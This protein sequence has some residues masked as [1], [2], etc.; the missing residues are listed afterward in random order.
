MAIV[1]PPRSY[2]RT[3]PLI[4]AVALFMENMD[5][6]VIATSLPAI[7]RA[8]GTNPLA[9]K[10]AVT[11]YLLALAIFIPASGWTADRFGAR[12][13]FRL[14]IFVFMLGSIGCA[15]SHSLEEF[16]LARIIQG[17]GG[18][19][20]TPV[21][22]LILVRSIDKRLLVNAMSLVTIPALVGPICGPPLGGFITTYASW[23]WIF[24][25]NIPIGLAG[26]AMATR[27]MPMVVA[28]PT[29][30]FDF[31]GFVL[32]GLG[33]GG[34]AFGLSVMGLEFL[35]AGIVIGLLGVGVTAT[36]A[37]IVHAR[38][39]ASP[40]LDLRLF[41]LP[42]F[43][44][45]IFGGFMFRLGIGALPF[46]LPL[47]LQIG[48]NLSPFQSGLITFTAAVGALFMKAAVAGILRHVGYRPVLI[49]NSLISAGFLA[50][51]ASFVPGMPFAAMVAILL[52]G[53][54][55]RSLQFTAV[56]TLA[57]AEIEPELTS[58]ATTL[59]SVAQQLALST[60]VAVGA[61][62]VELTLRLKHGAAISAEDFPAAFLAVGALTASSGFI[63][64]RLPHEAGAE[65][66]GREARLAAPAVEKK[67]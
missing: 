45:S 39:K 12:N 44:A 42:T 34:L 28:G 30:P 49:Y 29:V 4:V 23:H 15:L 2:S 25:I 56:N 52:V 43:R 55:F 20:M 22:R 54:F 9:L 16:V 67:S 66:A 21:G 60:G 5:S 40:I 37:Y 11:S 51:C 10:L 32:S 35:P 50:A 63:F 18:A 61:L 26:L 3:V 19:M 41:A 65:L 8:L 58:R 38:R 17:T 48:F 24:L 13:V 14:A 57:Y 6:T 31:V 36:A 53:G 33:V 1:E 64:A 46:L 62:V 47:L 7:A 59:V 27:Y